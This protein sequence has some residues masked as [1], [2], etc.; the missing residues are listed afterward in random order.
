MDKNKLANY[1]K[2]LIGESFFVVENGS[3][4]KKKVL[5]TV[6]S[7]EA[8]DLVV[9]TYTSHGQSR[10]ERAKY[11]DFL[12]KLSKGYLPYQSVWG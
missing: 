5:N 1:A 7:D 4:I 3:F 9:R 6:E 10:V 8:V 11:K 12:Y 2:G